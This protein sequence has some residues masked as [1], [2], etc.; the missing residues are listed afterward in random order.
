MA[1]VPVVLW[2]FAATGVVLL[3]A[4]AGMLLWTRAY[5]ARWARAEATVVVADAKDDSGNS[6]P[7]AKFW[8]AEFTDRRGLRQSFF[9]GASMEIP[10][11]GLSAESQKF[12]Q[13][14]SK[15]PILFDPSNPK[16]AKRDTFGELWRTPLVVLAV[17]AAVAIG[18]AA[19]IVLGLD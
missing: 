10:M 14:G 1:S 17:G 3:A 19:A 9:L 5:V 12:P 11:M 7:Q 13:P 2:V 6:V 16:R 8:H 18:S 15:I 4:G